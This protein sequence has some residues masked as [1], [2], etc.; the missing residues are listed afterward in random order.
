M[1]KAK[2]GSGGHGILVG[3]LIFFLSASS[4]HAI[5]Y[6]SILLRAG[7][8]IGNQLLGYGAGKFLDKVTGAD[9]EKQLRQVEA[10]LSRQLLQ[11]RGNNQ[12]LKTELEA[13]RYQLE[14]INS[15]LRSRPSRPQIS[16]YR[17]DLAASLDDVLRVQEEHDQR[18]SRLEAEVE[19]LSQ[20]LRQLD[21]SS[22]STPAQPSQRYY[23]QRQSVGS[24]SGSGGEHTSTDRIAL[25]ITLTGQNNAIRIKAGQGRRAGSRQQTVAISA[26]GKREDYILFV[27]ERAT[28]V[29]SGQGNAIYIQPSI[30][31]QVE[32]V[33]SGQNNQVIY[34]N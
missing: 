19:D 21:G 15:L 13:T 31:N 30:A 1:T 2:H 32:V 25:T 9:Y 12:K 34:E 29:V 8:W 14:I 5:S 18:I 3:L 27:G 11:Q 23:T 22:R 16:V 4:A 20:R 6:A 33:K 10:N 26:Q 24:T 28:V 7:A 17:R